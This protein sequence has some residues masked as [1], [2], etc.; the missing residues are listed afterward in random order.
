MSDNQELSAKGWRLFA[1]PLFIEQVE[2]LIRD[3]EVLRIKYPDSYK[4]KNAT[5]RLAAINDL[6]WDV[7][8]EDPTH[9]KYRQRGTLGK[10]HKHWYRAKFF[11][12]YRLSF[13]YHSA[14]HVIVYGW[15]N[16]T[17]TKRAYGHKNG[18][19]S[20]F[21]KILNS[22]HPPTDWDELLAACRSAGS[23]LSEL[24]TDDS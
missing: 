18:A 23:R 10:V 1:H 9:P 12:Q 11:Q 20:V 16:D 7:I 15:V 17:K 5:K 21:E 4:S 19:Y 2:A 13:R 24:M 8:P 22:G 3:V 6:I 14:N